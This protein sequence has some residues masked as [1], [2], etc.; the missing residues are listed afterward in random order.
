MQTRR[1]CL[2]LLLILCLVF[3]PTVFANDTQKEDD[4]NNAVVYLQAGGLCMGGAILGS[5]VPVLGTIAGCAVGA[6]AGWFWPGGSSDKPEP[7][8]VVLDQ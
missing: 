1:Y 6:V 3:S 2:H 5:V 8:E 7:R 4:D